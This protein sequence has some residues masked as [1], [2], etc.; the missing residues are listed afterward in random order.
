MELLARAV[1][2][3][4]GLVLYILERRGAFFCRKSV[5]L[6]KFAGGTCVRTPIL[7]QTLNACSLVS[8]TKGPSNAQILGNLGKGSVGH[9]RRVK[10]SET[11][12]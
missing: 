8:V 1:G 5:G 10:R 9:H 4:L 6:I 7:P 11:C 3:A 12:I 2:G